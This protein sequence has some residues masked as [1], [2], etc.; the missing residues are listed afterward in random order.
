MDSNVSLA[1]QARRAAAGRCDSAAQIYEMSGHTL[2][3]VG[4]MVLNLTNRLWEFV[5]AQEQ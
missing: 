4:S 2:R 3:A 5:R 1:E